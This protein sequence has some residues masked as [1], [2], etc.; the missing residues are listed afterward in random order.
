MLHR[1]VNRYRAPTKTG[2]RVAFYL[3]VSDPLDDQPIDEHERRIQQELLA[4]LLD[5]PGAM[6]TV[7]GIWTWWLPRHEA[8]MGIDRVAQA[9]NHLE[10]DG[11]IDRTGDPAHPLYRLRH[12]VKSDDGARVLSLESDPTISRHITGGDE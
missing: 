8:R 11:F 12:T 9:L 10:A 3:P 4:Y 7:E 1:I 5:N 2:A 6:D